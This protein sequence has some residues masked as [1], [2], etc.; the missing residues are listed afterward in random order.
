MSFSLAAMGMF[1]LEPTGVP[2]LVVGNDTLVG[3]SDIQ[4]R[5][6]SLIDQHLAKG[7]VDW[8][9]IRGL[10]AAIET[11]QAATEATDPASG[12]K[13]NLRGIDGMP[14]VGIEPTG[15]AG[16]GTQALSKVP[17]TVMR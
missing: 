16:V 6:S 5:F 11:T 9:D 3:S 14:D 13:D 7:G 4:N 10:R 15:Q 8:P 12:K 2:F 17:C 1:D